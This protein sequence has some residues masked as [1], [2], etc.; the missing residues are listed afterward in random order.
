[1]ADGPPETLWVHPC[2][3]IRDSNIEGKGL[4]ATEELAADVIVLRLSGHLV[5]TDELTRLIE[6]AN[7][8]PS[9]DYVDTLTIYEDAHLVLPPGS[10]VHFG[11][12]SC[13]PN[14]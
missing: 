12:H 10:L 11:N 13:D 7:A 9:H 2:V 8:D 14:M 3:V 6:H 4:F 1:M 5:T